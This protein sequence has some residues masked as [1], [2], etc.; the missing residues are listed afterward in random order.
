MKTLT[1]INGN[2]QPYTV[3]MPK[4]I[5]L[6]EHINDVA[7]AHIMENTGLVFNHIGYGYEA[8]PTDGAQISALFLTYN[9]KTRYY[10]NWQTKNTLY[11]KFDHHVGFQVDSICLDCVRHNRITVN[12][13]KDGDRLAC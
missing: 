12:D 9:F 3:D 1:L 7:L 2:K 11:L 10:N 4:L 13:L 6:T 5:I 8:Q